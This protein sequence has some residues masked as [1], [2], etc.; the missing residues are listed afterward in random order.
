MAEQDLALGHLMLDMDAI[1]L[2]T[3]LGHASVAPERSVVDFVCF[4]RFREAE[5]L[6]RFPIVVGNQ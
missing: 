1:A 2:P 3:S 6:I 4:R 5:V